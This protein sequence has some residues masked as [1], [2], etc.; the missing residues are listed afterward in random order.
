[1]LFKS[2]VLFAVFEY[3]FDRIIQDYLVAIKQIFTFT[4]KIQEQNL[5]E[6]EDNKLTFPEIGK[7]LENEVN[8]I[9]EMNGI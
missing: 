7:V 3:S 9:L 1:M 2:I 8:M 6:K 5:V 4:N